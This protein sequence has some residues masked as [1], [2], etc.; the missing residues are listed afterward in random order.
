M[1]TEKMSSWELQSPAGYNVEGHKQINISGCSD[2]HSD[3]KIKHGKEQ[4]VGGAVGWE[5]HVV[6]QAKPQEIKE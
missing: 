4:C 2:K 5:I 3:K 1:Q 6:M